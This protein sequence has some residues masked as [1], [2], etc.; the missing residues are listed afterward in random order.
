MKCAISFDNFSM[1]NSIWQFFALLATHFV[2]TIAT[3]KVC[4]THFCTFAID[5]LCTFKSDWQLLYNKFCYCRNRWR[6]LWRKHSILLEKWIKQHKHGCFRQVWY[7]E[8]PRRHNLLDKL[9]YYSRNLIFCFLEFLE[10]R[11][12]DRPTDKVTYT[13]HLEIKKNIEN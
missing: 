4:S 5:N 3:F 13:C 12:T 8:F 7:L 6:V 2:C 1:H 10:D 11:P 9:L